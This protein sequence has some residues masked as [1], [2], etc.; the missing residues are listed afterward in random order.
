MSYFTHKESVKE[1]LSLQSVKTHIGRG[2]ICMPIAG[3]RREREREREH[4]A[5]TVT[6][7]RSCLAIS[8]SQ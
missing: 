7:F 1:I 8:G 5:Y 3:M 6:F 2:N 4:D